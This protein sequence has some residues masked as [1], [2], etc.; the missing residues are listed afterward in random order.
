M[1]INRYDMLEYDKY[2][3]EQTRIKQWQIRCLLEARE[4][5]KNCVLTLTYNNDNLPDNGSLSLYD[6]QNFMKRLRK[7]VSPL[8]IRFFGC[9]EYGSKGQRP[10]YHII[11]FGW[12]PNDLIFHHLDN[13][14]LPFYLSDIVADIWNKG[15]IIVCPVITDTVIPYVCKYLQKFNNLPFGLVKPF[16]TMSRRPGI[17]QSGFNCLDFDNDKL[18]VDGKGVSIPRYYLMKLHN[19]DLDCKNIDLRYAVGAFDKVDKLLAKRR[20]FWENRFDCDYYLSSV[21][22]FKHFS[23]ERVS[24]RRPKP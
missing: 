17:G 24:V 5:D 21:K 2:H 13:K 4:H 14:G 10:H 7:Y 1:E 19:R 18:Y 15:Y 12:C 22:R 23:T 11:I 16:I 3:S 20:L 9:G 8:H 6:Y